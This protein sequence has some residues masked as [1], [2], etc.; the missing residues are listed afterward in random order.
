MKKKKDRQTVKQSFP[1]AA[2]EFEEVKRRRLGD[3]GLKT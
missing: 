2:E 3:I 1:V